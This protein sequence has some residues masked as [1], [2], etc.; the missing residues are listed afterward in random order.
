MTITSFILPTFF[1][2]ILINYSTQDVTVN[3]P[4]CSHDMDSRAIPS[5]TEAQLSKKSKTFTS[6]INHS[7]WCKNSI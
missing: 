6:P 7:S 1:L 5:L 2:I 4:Y 3:P